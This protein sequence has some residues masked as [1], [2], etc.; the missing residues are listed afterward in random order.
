MLLLFQGL[1]PGMLVLLGGPII[2]S[3]VHKAIA[4]LQDKSPATEARH[5]HPGFS[6]T[7]CHLKFGLT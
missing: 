4:K 7:D 3:C 2:C 5:T 6:V 1:I